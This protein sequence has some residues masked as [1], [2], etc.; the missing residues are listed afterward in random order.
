M[1]EFKISRLRF[2]WKGYWTTSTA[3]QIDDLIFYAGGSWS[4]IRGHTS[5]TFLEAQ[6]YL[7]T[8]TDTA[9]SPAWVKMTDGFQFKGVWTPN[10]GYLEGEIYQSGGNLYICLNDHA[11]G[12]YFSDNP[13]DWQIFVEGNNFTG[14]WT[15][16]TRYKT[17]DVIKYGGNTYKCITEH[18]STMAGIS[19][20]N[21][22]GSADS[23]SE[24]W[25]LVNTGI[26]FRGDW[27]S[28]T[29]YRTNDLISYS[30]SVLRCIQDH[31]SGISLVGFNPTLTL[32]RGNTYI[33]EIQ[34]KGHPFYIKTAQIPGT[35]STFDTGVT[36]NGTQEGTLTFTV[37]QN[38][39]SV[40]YY[41]CRNHG[42]M[43]GIINII[44]S[45][46]LGATG[47]SNNSVFTVYEQGM[48]S[49]IINGDI[50]WEVLIQGNSFKGG[51]SNTDY[52][53]KGDVVRSNSTFYVA[54][55]NNTRSE[56]G[57]TSKFPTGNIYW[58][59]IANNSTFQGDY[60]TSLDYKKGDLV[61]RGGSLWQAI[62]DTL[63]DGSSLDYID[64]TLWE[65][66]MPGQ[67]WRGA[68]DTNVFY[69]FND[70]V[71]Y[72]GT[73]YKAVQAHT[74]VVNSFPGDNGSGYNYW[75]ILIQGG[76]AGTEEIGDLLN[77]NY[78]RS[79][80][81]DTS[82]IGASRIPVG[83][84]DQLLVVEDAETIGYKTWGNVARVFHV[85][86]NGLDDDND[87]NRG[88]N[89]FKPFK[90][91]RYACEKADDGFAGTTTILVSTGLY[92]EV[93]PIILPARTAVVGEELRSVTVKA[94]DPI[95]ALA[96]DVNYSLTGLNRIVSIISN[97]LTGGSVVPSIGNTIAISNEVTTNSTIAL[98]AENLLTSIIHYITFNINN[99][100]ENPVVTGTNTAITTSDVLNAITNLTNNK[101]FIALEAVKYTKVIYGGSISFDEEKC[102]RDMR[103]YVEAMQWDLTYTSNYKSI[104][105]ARYYVNAVLGSS[106]E[107]M[108]YVRDE[109]GIR[110]LTMKGLVG[111]LA[112]PV[113][114]ELYRR[115]TGGSYVSLDPGWGPDD[116]R[117]WIYTRSC[118]VQNCTTFGYAATG[119][120][121]DGNIH[122]GGNRSIVS[123]DFT[124]VI[125]DGI[126]CHVLNGG[127]AELVSVFTYYAQI[128]MFAEDGGIIRA[129]NGNSSYGTFGALADGDDPDEVLR[130][131][132]MNTRTEEAQVGSAFAGEVNDYIL[133]LEFDNAGER[134]TTV[135]YSIT[136]S[137]YGATLVQ[138][139]FRD[140]GIFEAQ[141]QVPG[142]GY[143]ISGYNAQIGDPLTITFGT[144]DPSTADEVVG[145]R[146]I[147]VSGEGTGQYGYISTYDELDKIATV[148]RESNNQPGWDHVIPGTPSK[149]LLTTGTRYR[150]EPRVTFSTPPF[151]ASLITLA[152]PNSWAGLVY[153]ETYEI[154]TGVSV[155]TGAAV[156]QVTKENRNYSLSLSLGGL[157]YSPGD[158][159][160]IYGNL[161]GGDAGEH[162]IKITVETTTINGTILD[163]TYRGIGSSGKFVA[164]PSTGSTAIYSRS[165]DVWTEAALPA[166]GN[167]KV[168]AAGELTFVAIQNGSNIAAFS[169]NGI[170]WTQ[171]TMPNAGF[172]NGC[173]YGEGVFVAVAA[174]GDYGAI[175][176][177]GQSW[178]A[179]NLPNVGDS[180]IN[181]WQDIAYGNGKFVA[182]ANSNNAV[183]VGTYNAG[184]NTI[185]WTP[186]V[187][188]VEDSSYQDWTSI[189]Y[190]NGRFVAVSQ[191]GYVAYSFNGI[192]WYTLTGGMPQPSTTEMYWRKIR[193]GQGVFFAVCTTAASTA[194]TF[195]A[196]SYDGIVWTNRT[197]STG[198][199]WGLCA[200]GSVDVD[201]GDSTVSNNKP[202]WIIAPIVSS[203][204][205]NKVFTGARALGRAVVDT[206]N[207]SK[208]RLWEPGSG[209]STIP[210]LSLTD[211]NNLT[212]AVIKCRVG[213]GVLGQPTF[214]TRG[215]FYKTST[216]SVKITG[217]GYADIQPTG[218]Y[219][220]IDNLQVMPG[221][222]AQFYI[223]GSQNYF[224]AVQVNIE[225]TTNPDGTFRST[226]QVSPAVT[227]SDN[228][229]HNQEV[230]VR[231]RYSQV[232]IT[233]HDFLDVG[234]GN[235][236]DTNYPDLYKDYLFLRQPEKE[237]YQVNG[238]RVFYTSTDQDG[239]FRAGEYFAV[240]QA[241]GIVTISAD[242]FD[243]SGLT[244]LALGGIVVGGTGTVIREFS[245]DPEFT[246][247]SN[248]IVPTQKAIIAYL[249]SRLNIGGEDLLTASFIAGTVKVGPNEINS[250][251]GID[252][253]FP[254]I[255][256]FPALPSSGIQ[257]SF[258]AQ[259][260]FYNSFN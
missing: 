73:T 3:Y 90:T 52:Y 108:F 78:S 36:N 114:E 63:A 231:E 161:V 149:D 10:I 156:F 65:L 190:G 227:L 233:G 220:T 25:E 1:A 177:N 77:L 185:S 28:N 141:V 163:Y 118:Y 40:L 101:E 39:P 34:A 30:G 226:F 249:Q 210:S 24:T 152:T 124:Q 38:S 130:F 33:F 71:Y 7:A 13:N 160:I 254:V 112:Q 93:L 98:Q 12:S 126:G 116:Q 107:D 188:E 53:V 45:P 144:N 207:I 182:I 51:W 26:Y 187:V 43:S 27:S 76:F 22:S 147:I 259:Q 215:Q 229:Q 102:K 80:V 19:V 162:D 252:V 244:E 212:D 79:V 31:T 247:N 255:V 148:Y 129:T 202:M 9:F 70:T 219:I 99:S 205:M 257:G 237:V 251:A 92:E 47:A 245:K 171:T 59:P 175:S 139:E 174:D 157:G 41:V 195:A 168:T 128:G 204:Y 236:D 159:L 235:F 222:G 64:P 150:I 110:N 140:N 154:F 69:N 155:D 72:K 23:V 145:C 189:A 60:N 89:Y 29:F 225:S 106:G 2:N 42:G 184:P 97:I 84:E 209:Y 183:A 67:N 62:Q 125:S 238:G 66:V 127:R 48:D 8:P 241:S 120:K 123:N 198:L 253:Q 138:E 5:T 111:T 14:E 158:E 16:P 180:S 191:Q 208:I 113:G 117:T 15:Y 136:S 172:W 216:T 256:N 87:P 243:L 86:T 68:W 11:G 200:F 50:N 224:T 211:P 121:I 239:N 18:T 232:R 135:N 203:L 192:K 234:T 250:T 165:G 230:L 166:D 83:L 143:I 57:L 115:P 170:S 131:G 197:L 100:G 196:T 194:T 179:T 173:T 91:I 109:T 4:C 46:I 82:T 85:R 104:L 201:L 142:T 153:S 240:E 169:R 248:N 95:E 21:N 132:N 181:Y 122:N 218:K 242:F 178:V 35:G 103:R 49:Y 88:I 137:G 61:K 193:Y 223:G 206:G 258:L 56:P 74:S 214:S 37:P 260:Y 96:N 228:L 58:D 94:N 217:D 20:G 105:A 119:Q 17:G 44:D 213:D 164:T 133:A 146:I 167:W 54:K 186:A 55:Y 32:V 6:N 221:P 81:G 176:T 134:Y 246:Q 199:N 75:D 151:T